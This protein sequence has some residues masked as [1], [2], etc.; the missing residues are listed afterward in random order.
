MSTDVEFESK[1]N[2]DMVGNI[3]VTKYMIAAAV[4]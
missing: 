2:F 4:E 1:Y 3:P